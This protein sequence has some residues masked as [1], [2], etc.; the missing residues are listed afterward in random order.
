MFGRIVSLTVTVN[1]QRLVLPLL[2]VATQMTVLTPLLK[3]E[4]L[5]GLQATV[6]PPQLS[7]AV[8]EKITRARHSLVSVLTTMSLGQTICGFSTSRTITRNAQVLELLLASRAVHV[9]EFVP[10]RK[11]LPDGG[12]HVTVTIE[13]LSDVC[14]PKKT[15]ASQRPVA[16]FTSISDGHC[17]AGASASRTVTV[18]W[19]V[20]V[21]E[22][23]SVAEQFTVV[24]PTAK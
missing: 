13:Q 19:Q 23:P 8:A 11:V 1:E 15:T 14:V 6:T 2:S 4:L 21:L 22:L 16:V 18:N 20:P 5:G 3:N 12:T 9:T 10:F 17:R 7:V 24:A